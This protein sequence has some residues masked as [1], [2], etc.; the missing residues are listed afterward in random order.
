MTPPSQRVKIEVV[1][2]VVGSLQHCSRRQILFDNAGIG[3]QVRQQDLASYPP[4]VQEEWEQ[5]TALL[6]RLGE[7]FPSQL[8]VQIVNA[9]SPRGLWLALRDVR[10]YPAFL[11]GGERIV[12]F[13]EERIA[14]AITRALDEP[15]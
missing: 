7:R 8:F 9:Q 11:V 3:D 15:R 2:R 4:E 10:R 1:A 13:D 5:L 14:A 12:G 6:S